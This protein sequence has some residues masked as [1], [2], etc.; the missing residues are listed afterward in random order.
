MLRSLGACFA[1]WVLSAPT[2]L[3]PVASNAEASAA[4]KWTVHSWGPTGTDQ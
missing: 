3:S 1:V 4:R 2:G